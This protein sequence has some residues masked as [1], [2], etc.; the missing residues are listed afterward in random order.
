MKKH[1]THEHNVISDRLCDEFNDA[2]NTRELAYVAHL[3]VEY[4]LNELI[5]ATFKFPE[6]IIDSN[7]LG[8]FHSKLTLLRAHGIFDKKPAVLRN[9]ELIQRIRNHYAH[10]L[11]MTNDEPEPVVSRVTELV[12]FDWNGEIADYDVPWREHE[13][14]IM[15]QLQVCAT[16]TTNALVELRESLFP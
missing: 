2:A 1:K 9:V 5:V 11:L 8:T 4:F 6:L 10:N 12:Y 15:A 14:P 16:A 7:D 3:Y 13:N